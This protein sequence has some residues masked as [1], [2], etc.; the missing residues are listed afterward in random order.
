MSVSKLQ[1]RKKIKKRSRSSVHGTPDRP[2]LCVY[3]SNKEIY[4]QLIDDETG[5]TILSVS[6]KIKNHSFSGSKIEIASEVGKLMAQK[7]LEQG[8]SA[9]RFDRNGFLFHGRVLALAQSAREAGL[10]F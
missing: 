10:V 7:S 1:R 4:A 2:R 5:N 9:V 8:V 3:K 6:S